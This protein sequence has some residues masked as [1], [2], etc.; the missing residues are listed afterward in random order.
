MRLT[1]FRSTLVAMVLLCFCSW[2]TLAQ[3]Q[4]QLPDAPAPQQNVPPP[5]SEIPAQTPNSTPPPASTQPSD[6]GQP[7]GPSPEQPAPRST[8]IETVPNGQAPNTPGSGSDELA[9]RIKVEVNFVHL[10]VTVKDDDGHLVEGLL[11]RDFAIFENGVE[12]N[13]SFFSSD[14]F[15]LSAAVVLDLGMSNSAVRKVRET[16]SA[17]DGAFGPYDEISVYTYGN[18]VHKQQDFTNADA[19]MRTLRTLRETARGENE[20]VPITSGPLAS[21][22][23]ING[24]PAIEG[25]PHVQNVDQ[26][27]RVMNDAI[28]QAAL[29]LASRPAN[30]R[31]VLF[32]I[33][34]GFEKG[35]NSSYGDV[36]RVLLSK[37]ITVYGI[38]VDAAALPVYRSAERIHI[39]GLG[40]GNILPRYASATGGSV[41]PE[42]GRQAIENAY[43][44]VTLEA[45]NQYTLGYNTHVSAVST[46]RNI[47][48][49]IHRPGLK[50]FAKEAYYP[51]PPAPAKPGAP[52]QQPAPQ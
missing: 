15:P 10:P 36:L 29:D 4:A 24:K 51:L 34:D 3:A 6:Q 7:A 22:P 9:Y 43:Q 11:K 17:L 39:P 1:I 5:S 12:Q 49:R 28:L 44:Q 40:T 42:G 8:P 33:S 45:R 16:L 37:E 26:P 47:E 18:T 14:P 52:P 46:R 2:F 20:G 48:V 25:T 50:I 23:T 27:S 30:R 35:S 32:V 21:G 41:F 19:L 31:K 38:G 13:I